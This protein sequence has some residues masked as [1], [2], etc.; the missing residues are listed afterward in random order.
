V[1]LV[2]LSLEQAGTEVL[3]QIS[4]RWAAIIMVLPLLARF[5]SAQLARPVDH[6]QSRLPL[7]LAKTD[8]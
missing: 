7:G 4:N 1:V 2:I 3:P 8:Q 6:A 5:G